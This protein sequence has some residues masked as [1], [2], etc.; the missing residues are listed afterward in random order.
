MVRGDVRYIAH[1]PGPVGVAEL[2]DYAGLNHNAVRSHLAVLKDC[3]LV[4]E[5]LEK[6]DRIGAPRLLYRLHREAIGP[7]ER[8]GLYPSWPS[9]SAKR[10]GATRTP[11]RL[12]GGREPD[13]HPAAGR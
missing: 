1:A 8:S 3:G 6:R 11:V 13:G 9:C 10:C 12:D 4:V 5:E 7:W 2:T